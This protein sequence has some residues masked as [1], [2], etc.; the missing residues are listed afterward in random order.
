VN[1]RGKG[2]KKQTNKS[3]S[4]VYEIVQN[5][6]IDGRQWL[7]EIFQISTRHLQNWYPNCKFSGKIYIQWQQFMY[8]V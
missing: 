4:L 8:S 7:S 5:R 6:I 2:K 1:L 3:Y